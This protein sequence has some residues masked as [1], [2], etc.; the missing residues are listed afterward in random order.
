MGFVGD[1]SG[2]RTG[3]VL[4]GLMLS[5]DM[6]LLLSNNMRLLLLLLLLLDYV[7]L[8]NKSLLARSS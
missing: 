8:L 7:M 2:S 6:R 5:E 4:L 3:Y 1:Y